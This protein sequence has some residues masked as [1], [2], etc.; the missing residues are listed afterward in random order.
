[1]L[2][3]FLRFKYFRNNKLNKVAYF[4]SFKFFLRLM[5]LIIYKTAIFDGINCTSNSLN[6]KGFLKNL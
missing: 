2:L 4:V 6:D 3:K 1:M 5:K